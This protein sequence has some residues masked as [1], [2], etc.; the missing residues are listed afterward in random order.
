[1]HGAGPGGNGQSGR[2]ADRLSA[3]HSG[4]RHAAFSHFFNDIYETICSSL[5]FSEQSF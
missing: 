1:M 4:T 5:K 2:T 3:K